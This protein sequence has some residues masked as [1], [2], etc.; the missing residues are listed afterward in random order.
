[1]R[2]NDTYGPFDSE[3]LAIETPYA[4]VALVISATVLAPAFPKAPLRAGRL[5]KTVDN[6]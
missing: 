5:V 6:Q 1:M 2:V 3:S 4:T